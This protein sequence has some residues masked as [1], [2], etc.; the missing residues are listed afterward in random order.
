M[1]HKKDLM[2]RLTEFSK[3]AL[4]ARDYDKA[5]EEIEALEEFMAS[6]KALLY[7][8]I[9]KHLNKIAE[10]LDQSNDDFAL[11]MAARLKQGQMPPQG[12]LGRTI[13]VLASQKGTHGSQEYLQ[14]E[15]RIISEFGSIAAE[16][17]RKTEEWKEKSRELLDAWRTGKGIEKSDSSPDD[18]S[19][20]QVV[21]R[22]K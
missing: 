21:P 3:K 12:M 17:D 5:T 19:P 16:I 1:Q 6:E 13:G 22:K 9:H 2:Q 15:S 14:E 11:G 4:G 7:A 8:N 10:R 18:D 20:Q